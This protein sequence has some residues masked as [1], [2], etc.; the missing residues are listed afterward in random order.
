MNI[1]VTGASGFIGNALV[2]RLIQHGHHV[3]AVIHQKPPSLLDCQVNYIVAD[4][5]DPSTLTT[6][7][8]DVDVVFHCAA[9]VHDYGSTKKILET[10]IQGTKNLAAACGDNIKR[11][12]FLSHLPTNSIKNL[13]AYSYSKAIAEQYLL[14]KFH[15]TR[16]PVVIIR[17]GNVYGPGA[18][19]WVLRP[20][21]AI[22]QG[23]IALIN[24]G[25]G[26]FLHTYIDNLVDALLSTLHAPNA[27]GETIEITDGEPMITWARYLNDLA[28]IAN[29]PP[30]T[31]NMGKNTALFL[32]TLMMI[33]YALFH[34]APL[35]T[36]TAVRIFTNQRTVSLDKARTILGYTPSVEYT[37]GMEQTKKWLTTEH[38]L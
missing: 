20:L 10:N 26:I 3:R 9:L 16:F 6:A 25:T 22:Q 23:R 7:V 29:K 36:P 15:N 27:V 11:F 8:K 24:N 12:V 30:I 28:E 37:K 32:S 4:I 18:T 17:P 33:R 35:L 5:T 2:Q 34:T 38:Y 1:L 14:E 19:T 21:H 13:D 31:K